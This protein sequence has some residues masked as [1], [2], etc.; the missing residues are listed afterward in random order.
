[1]RRHFQSKTRRKDIPGGGMKE[2]G[3]GICQN[4]SRKSKREIKS[5]GVHKK[6]MSFLLRNSMVP[7][8]PENQQCPHRSRHLSAFFRVLAFCPVC[9]HMIRRWLLT[10]MFKTGRRR[11]QTQ[12]NSLSLFVLKHSRK[13]PIL[14]HSSCYNEVLQSVWLLTTEVYFSEQWRLEV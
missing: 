7:G 4:A 3:S 1:M 14:V 10:N 12:G 2:A 5:S 6:A 11:R 13:Y 9:Y 8:H